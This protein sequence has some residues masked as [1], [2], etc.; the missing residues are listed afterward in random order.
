MLRTLYL[1]HHSRLMQTV[2]VLLYLL[3]IAYGSLYPFTGWRVPLQ[4]A[5]SFLFAPWP[6]YVTRTDLITNVLAYMPLGYLLTVWLRVYASRWQTV[7]YATL[8]GALYSLTMESLQAFLPGRIASNLDILTNVAGAFIGV[9][10]YRLLQNSKWPGRLLPMWREQRFAPGLW[11]DV[12]LLLLALWGL[13]QFSLDMPSLVAGNLKTRFIPVW[14]LTGNWRD[15]HPLHALIYGLESAV[16]TLYIACLLRRWPRPPRSLIL[17]ISL[18]IFVWAC[19]LL[20]AALLLKG[21]VLPR[22]LSGEV[23]IGIALA[24]VFIV[25]ARGVPR[26]VRTR[27]LVILLAAA[28]MLQWWLLRGTAAPLPGTGSSAAVPL[29]ITA[30]AGWVALI[31]PFLVALFLLP[32]LLPGA[33]EGTGSAQSER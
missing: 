30:L 32:P 3:L 14:E 20:A 9:A 33:K 7:V 21:W 28:G 27:S 11:G 13:S 31:W 26:G 15:L 24:V 25:W 10:L 8:G 6:R 5:W 4:D 18:F 29:N 17:W 1:S 2:A 16:A 22:L 19:K 23:L 12:G